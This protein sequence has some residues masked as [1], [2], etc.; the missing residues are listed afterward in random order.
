MTVSAIAKVKGNGADRYDHHEELCMQMVV[1]K[2]AEKWQEGHC[3]W[4][5]QT[6]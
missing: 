1:A 2:L 3:K 4:Q 5:Q 6:M